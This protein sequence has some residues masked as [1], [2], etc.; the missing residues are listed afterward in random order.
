MKNFILKHSVHERK[1][2][3]QTP[4]IICFPFTGANKN[5]EVHGKQ[6]LIMGQPVQGAWYIRVRGN[7]PLRGKSEVHTYLAPE[8]ALTLILGQPGFSGF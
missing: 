5:P 8:S 3:D 4:V 6:K 2:S 1:F 7:P